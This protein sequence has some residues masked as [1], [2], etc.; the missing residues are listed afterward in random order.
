[1]VIP[2]ILQRIAN[3]VG[4]TPDRDE[5]PKR[6]RAIICSPDGSKV[7]GIIRQKPGR[8]PYIVY[9]GGGIEEEDSTAIA[10]IRRELLEELNLHD[11]DIL[12]DER[13]L[14]FS[15]EVGGDQ[16][17]YLGVAREEFEDLTIHGPESERD[18]SISGTYLPAWIPIGQSVS[19]NFQ[20]PEVSQLIV[21]YR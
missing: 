11:E 6:C 18:Q 21:A 3:E 8:D 10:A 14:R 1:M 13:V 20:P 5:R 15:D 2:E 7:L 4:Y 16:F 17:Y 9:P 12:L 19:A